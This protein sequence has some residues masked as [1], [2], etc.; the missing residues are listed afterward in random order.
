MKTCA[1][2]TVD[3][4]TLQT[5]L[6]DSITLKQVIVEKLGMKMQVPQGMH[7]KRLKKRIQQDNLDMTKFNQNHETYM[8]SVMRSSAIS[9][10]IED[11]EC[12]KKDSNHNRCGIKRRILANKTIPHECALCKIGPSWNGQELSLELDHINQINNDNR[13]ENLRFLCPNCHSQIT[14]AHRRNKKKSMK[15][16]L[17]NLCECGNVKWKKSNRCKKCSSKH[18]A[19]IARNFTRRFDPSK[20]ELE[21][22]L[23]Q[24]NYNVRATGRH[25]SVSDNAIRKRCRLLGV[26]WKV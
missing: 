6:D 23:Q 12:F 19:I 14:N 11:D 15:D 22:A 9:R 26:S 20:E 18:N 10:K 24:H 7:Y 8:K 17:K 3:T 16:I 1:I 4:Q 25:Y 13:I 21:L 5:Y 2:W